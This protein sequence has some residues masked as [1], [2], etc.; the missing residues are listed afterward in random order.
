MNTTK[1][2]ERFLRL[3]DKH[4]SGFPYVSDYIKEDVA[5]NE[6]TVKRFELNGAAG[7]FSAFNDSGD[8]IALLKGSVPWMSVTPLEIE[9]HFMAQHSAKGHVVIAG[10]GLGMITMSLLRKARVDKVTV[11]EISQDLIDS[12]GS[13]LIGKSKDLYEE[14]LNN[15]RLEIIQCDCESPLSNEVLSKVKGCDYAWIDT[16]ERLGDEKSLGKVVYLQEQIKAKTVDFWGMELEFIGLMAKRSDGS[17]NINKKRNAF[18]DVVADFPIPVSAKKLP[19]K[20]LSFYFEL[21]MTAGVMGMMYMRRNRAK[22]S[23]AIHMS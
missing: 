7:Y 9:S 10:L 22:K 1:Q 13:I 4:F 19:A 14:S 18:L 3:I 20:A 23:L 6:W 12:F 5:I 16:W 17:D 21:V 8:G 2:S 15:G 11:L